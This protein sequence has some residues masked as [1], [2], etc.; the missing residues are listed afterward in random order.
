MFGTILEGQIF[1]IE[2]LALISAGT[3][4]NLRAG[5][6]GVDMSF[7]QFD[8]RARIADVFNHIDYENLIT[9]MSILFFGSVFESSRQ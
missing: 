3:P 4:R 8:Q 2:E 5:E 9:H 7:H 1:T 6:L